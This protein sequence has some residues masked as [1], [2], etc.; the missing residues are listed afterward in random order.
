MVSELCDA[1]HFQ[2]QIN[3]DGELDYGQLNLHIAEMIRDAGPWGQHFPAPQ[4]DGEFSLIEQRIVGGK[5]LKC[6]LRPAQSDLLLDAIAFNVD[7]QAWPNRQC[8]TIYAA[9]QLDVNEYRG[10]KKVQLIIN[11]FEAV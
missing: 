2:R 4:F 9:Y 5:H 8:Q 7:E 1:S 11:E 3:S 6:V 10:N